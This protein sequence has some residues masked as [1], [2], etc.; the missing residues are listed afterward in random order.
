MIVVGGTYVEV[1]DYPPLRSV[2]GSGLRAAGALAATK[3]IELFSA[4]DDEL[5]DEARS[6]AGG[7]GVP[8][9]T[10]ARDQPVAFRYFTPLSS[11]AIDGPGARCSDPIDVRGDTVLLFGMIEQV[12]CRVESAKVVLD[13][14]RPRDLTGISRD[15]IDSEQLALV[16]NR[17]E[18]RAIGGTDNLID[19]AHA[20]GAS[21]QAD[22]VVVKRGAIGCTVVYEDQI[23][24][25]GP[26]P[27]KTVWPI[28]S[29]DVFAAGFAYAWGEG[30]DPVA[31]ARIGSAAA[32]WWCGIRTPT[33]P[34]ALLNGEPPE[35]HMLPERID[36]VEDPKVY[37]AG[38]FFCLGERWL[39]E[40]ARDAALGL[41]AD[42]FSP[43]H[44]VGPGG[45]EVA[46]RDLEGLQTAGAVLAL[47]DG[48]DAGT[49]YECGW[50]RKAGIPVIAHGADATSEGAKMLV[51]D[52][53]EIHADFTSA[54]YRAVWAAMGAAVQ[55]ARVP[56]PLGPT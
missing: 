16:C 30:A 44:D 24:H 51:G 56:G 42:V 43:L 33:V 52:G 41:G 18:V 12:T 39:V 15:G 28:G 20:A 40:T 31:A 38:P 49:I 48:Y 8:Y 47:I 6:T 11:P 4:V 27:T 9:I 50:A 55:G 54:V 29:G 5:G 45:D 46:A 3:D 25:V 53:A 13:P 34:L 36:L 23:A 32:A 21:I 17:A 26:H 37:L 35:D 19:A 10:V 7:L 1:T 22:V 14:Q 2:A